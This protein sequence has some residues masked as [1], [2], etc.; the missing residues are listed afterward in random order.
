MFEN[1]TAKLQAVFDKIGKR[2]KLTDKDG[3]V[4]PDAYLMKRGS[5]ASPMYHRR[6]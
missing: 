1:L 4:L 5:T 2:G 6:R 3:R